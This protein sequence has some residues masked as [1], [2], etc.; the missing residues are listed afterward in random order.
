MNTPHDHISEELLARYL[1]KT[2][3]EAELQH[4]ESWL[5][6]SPLHAKELNDF[7]LIWKHSR[8]IGAQSRYNVDA[9]WNKVRE[10]M[11]T[12]PEKQVSQFSESQ[13]IKV[14]S[15]PVKKHF[16]VTVLAAAA[17]ALFVMAFG[18]LELR[19]ETKPGLLSVSTK[20]NVQE[21][22]LPD[23]TKV[24]LNFNSSIS[25]P[26][27]FEGEIR[28]V[29]LTG[30]AFFDVKP[31]ASHPFVIDAN[32]AEI[33]VLGT[34]FNVKAYNKMPIR[35]DVSTGKVQVSKANKKINLIK[36][37]SAEVSHDTV[38]SILPDPNLLGYRTQIFDFNATQLEDVVTSI[39]EGY[40]AD[41]RLAGGQ[42]SRCRLTIRFEKEPLD[43]TL[44]VIAETM[45][46][47]IR[48]EGK[49]YWLDGAGCP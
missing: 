28:A 8:V 10:K 16:P 38:R 4:I 31:D 32:G 35:V 33:K 40:H 44:A 41:V 34:S 7:E 22:T 46:L 17:V 20:S 3:T 47:K 13:N 26:E 6:S 48:H 45:E 15:L 27:N 29:S 39:R 37:Q 19:K 25:Y 18:W 1:A 5:A 14:K 21:A 9:A 11:E 12:G 36:G 30:E 49:I 24:F 43:A 23:G 42:L 2:A